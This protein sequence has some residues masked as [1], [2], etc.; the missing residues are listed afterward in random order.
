L[1]AE[2]VNNNNIIEN[3]DLT[4]SNFTNS[5]KVFTDSAQTLATGI[6]TDLVKATGSWEN[7]HTQFIK[8]T[9]LFDRAIQRLEPVIQELPTAID[10]LELGVNTIQNFGEKVVTLSENTGQIA[11]KIESH[12]H[13]ILNS[14]DTSIGNIREITQNS[15]QSLIELFQRNF[16][17]HKNN[18][19]QLLQDIKT[20]LSHLSLSE[21]DDLQRLIATMEKLESTLNLDRSRNIPPRSGWLNRP[22]QNP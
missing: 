16:Q 9:V 7:T 11:E 13:Q 5:Q 4:I 2:R 17:A 10:A 20:H 6:S 12:H 8:S 3:L 1:G 15:W 22:S 14:T 18:N 19:L 21:R